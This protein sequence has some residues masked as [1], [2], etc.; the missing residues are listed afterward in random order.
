MK[1]LSTECLYPSPESQQQ[2]FDSSFNKQI[3]ASNKSWQLRFKHS[4]KYMTTD[5]PSLHWGRCIDC[6]VH[7]AT[8]HSDSG[9]L[10]QQG[11][12]YSEHHP[13]S[14][15]LHRRERQQNTSFAA[16]HLTPDASNSGESGTINNSISKYST[17]PQTSVT[18]HQ[19]M[20]K[21]CFLMENI[22][23]R[24]SMTI[25]RLTYTTHT[26]LMLYQ[27]ALLYI[28]SKIQ[29]QHDSYPLCMV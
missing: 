14:R 26:G 8:A 4:R 19:M 22:G 29:L 18:G 23:W 7:M 1:I 11:T 13:K 15:P 25:Y 21:S 12:H 16:G 28:I 20:A 17:Q 24:V 2:R 27:G 10:E 6:R 9:Q 3:S 5:Q